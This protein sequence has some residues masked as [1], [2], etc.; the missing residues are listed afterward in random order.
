[1]DLTASS[2]Y[3]AI[4]NFTDDNRI[5]RKK[6]TASFEDVVD[7]IEINEVAP[8]IRTT[9]YSGDF[10]HLFLRTLDRKFLNLKDDEFLNENNFSNLLT[11]DEYQ[12][13]SINNFLL[14]CEVK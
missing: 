1:M 3:V 6:I 12:L 10:P 7:T 8:A 14:D 13:S 2:Y 11:L 9:E 5:K 4:E